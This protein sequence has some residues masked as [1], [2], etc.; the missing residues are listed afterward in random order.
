MPS[1]I[2]SIE[3][4]NAW[5]SL[6][7]ETI[8]EKLENFGLKV[9]IKNFNNKHIKIIGK[10]RQVDL[11]AST[12]TVSANKSSS[13]KYCSYKEMMP[14]RAFKRILSLSNIGY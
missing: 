11:Y 6:S 4:R 5:K 3:L 2:I 1:P 7:V 10:A 13:F 14:E 8:K 9:E 12:G